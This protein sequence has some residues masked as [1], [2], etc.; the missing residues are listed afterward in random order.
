LYRRSLYT[1]W[2]RTT[3]PPMMITFDAADRNVCLVRRQ[4]TSTPL[5]ALVMLNDVQVVEAARQVAVRARREGGSTPEARLAWMFRLVTG[6][7]ARPAE[8]AVARDLLADERR[9]FEA[10]PDAAAKWLA[11]G[12]SKL[13]A[14]VPC[15]PDLAAETAVAAALFNHDEALMRR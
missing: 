6:R 12:E 13:P 1:F 9:E 7:H 11:V 8:L 3:P 14:D 10:S 15:G 2:K 4:S 5:Q